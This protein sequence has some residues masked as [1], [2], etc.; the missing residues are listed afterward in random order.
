MIII[1]FIFEKEFKIYL[2]F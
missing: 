1:L 2:C